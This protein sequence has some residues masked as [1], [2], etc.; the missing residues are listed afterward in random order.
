[1]F[2]GLAAGVGLAF[3]IMKARRRSRRSADASTSGP[4]PAFTK[5]PLRERSAK[6]SQLVASWQDVSDA[7]LGVAIARAVEAIADRVPGFKAQYE[8]RNAMRDSFR[9]AE[10]FTSGR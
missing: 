7:L 1:M 5:P 8:R 2:L 9:S 6:V 3:G 4:V 10:V